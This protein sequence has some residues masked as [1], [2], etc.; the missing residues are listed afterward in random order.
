VHRKALVF[1]VVLAASAFLAVMVYQTFEIYPRTD[2]VQASREA[3]LNPY[4]A[5]DR[6]LK[7]TG[8]PVRVR[9]SG[10]AKLITSAPE[11]IVFIQASLFTWSGGLYEDLKPWIEQGGSLILSLDAGKDGGREEPADLP[12]FLKALGLRRKYTASGSGGAPVDFD[13]N[14]IL[15]PVKQNKNRARLT[16][17]KDARGIIRLVTL[18]LGQGSVTVMGSPR[19]MRSDLVGKPENAQ[20]AWD[21]T[22]GRDREGGGV[23]FIRGAGRPESFYTKLEERGNP[24]FLIISAL[25]VIGLGFWMVIPAFGR[26]QKDDE[27]PGKPIRERFLAEARFLKKFRALDTYLSIYIQEL[28]LKFRR[29]EGSYCDDK[30]LILRLAALCGMDSDTVE[31]ALR[32]RRG[33]TC[34]EFIRQREILETLLERL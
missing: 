22:G 33:L 21:L 17:R 27:P 14:L 11:K 23:F 13:R 28:K 1:G 24:V 16:S 25:T 29:R 26:P 12:A 3:R 6:W 4:L 10:N 2:W 8:H 19:F 32:P 20:L 15:K 5:L 30:T 9:L 7:K 34:R 31:K 18:S